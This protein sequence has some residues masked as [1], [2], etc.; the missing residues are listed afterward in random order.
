MDVQ[1]QLFGFMA[2]AE[3]HQK[4]VKAALEG[5][6]VE[7][8]ALAKERAA[9]AQAAASVARIAGEVRQATADAVS[10]SVRQSLTGVS[11]TAAKALEVAA[12]PVIDR[13]SGVVQAAGEV[14]GAMRNAGAWFAWKWVAVA[15]GGLLGVC[16]AAYGALAWQLHQISSLRGEKAALQ[17]DIEEMRTNVAAL[18]KRGGRII[19]HTCGGRWCIEASSNQGEGMT[20]W[21]GPWKT[22]KR[23]PLVIPR[24]Y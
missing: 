5:L 24:G 11:D 2:V 8:A 4:A 19:M 7:R 22:D 23:V 1:Q 12:T 21:H 15:A 3:E 14:E 20:D 9:V 10:A 6:A 17:A 16:L 13:L 18:E